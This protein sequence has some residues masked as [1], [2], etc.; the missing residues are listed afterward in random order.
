[1]DECQKRNSVNVCSAW[2]NNNDVIDDI[3]CHK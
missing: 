1:M 2:S 3:D